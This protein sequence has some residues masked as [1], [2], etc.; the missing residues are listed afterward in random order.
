MQRG[1]NSLED[2]YFGEIAALVKAHGGKMVVEGEVKC[3]KIFIDSFQKMKACKKHRAIIMAT[4]YVITREKLILTFRIYER[5]VTGILCEYD[6][7]LVVGINIVDVFHEDIY[8][9]LIICHNIAFVACVRHP[10]QV[11]IG[12]EMKHVYRITQRYSA[13]LNDGKHR[14]MPKKEI[15][16][17]A[18][19]TVGEEEYEE[20]FMPFIK[21][22]TEKLNILIGFHEANPSRTIDIFEQSLR[23][24]ISLLMWGKLKKILSKNIDYDKWKRAINDFYWNDDSLFISNL[25][26]YLKDLKQEQ[27]N[28]NMNL[29]KVRH[30]ILEVGKL[31]VGTRFVFDMWRSG[32]HDEVGNIM[33][34]P[35]KYKLPE[36]KH[37]YQYAEIGDGAL[38]ADFKSAFPGSVRAFKVS[39]VNLHDLPDKQDLIDMILTDIMFQFY[40]V[41]ARLCHAAA[42]HFQRYSYFDEKTFIKNPL[43]GSSI[44][45]GY[46]REIYLGISERCIEV[47]KSFGVKPGS[48]KETEKEIWKIILKKSISGE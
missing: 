8:E 36:R 48:M 26:E 30:L 14:S 25:L 23:D 24:K 47:M 1:D 42:S 27:E 16:K 45:Y 18:H 41:P 2:N 46:Q 3:R 37:N 7:G 32:T 40:D 28:Q 33:N 10:L 12:H 13:Y 5:G 21:N 38:L 31:V 35:I 43:A 29:G 19:D 20:M 17:L 11:V 22:I 34:K 39:S 4:V 9:Y 44:M 15:L 6:N